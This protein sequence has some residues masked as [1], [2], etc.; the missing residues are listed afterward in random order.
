MPSLLSVSAS[1]AVLVVLAAQLHCSSGNA[2]VAP[3]PQY[4]EIKLQGSTLSIVPYWGK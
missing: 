1:A 2:A 3:T 4:T